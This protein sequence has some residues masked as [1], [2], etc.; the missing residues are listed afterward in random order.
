MGKKCDR[1]GERNS[2]FIELDLLLNPLHI[3]KVNWYLSLLIPWKDDFCMTRAGCIKL[4][5]PTQ[6]NRTFLTSL[7]LQ[8]AKIIRL[9]VRPSPYASLWVFELSPS[10]RIWGSFLSSSSYWVTPGGYPCHL[11]LDSSPMSG[12]CEDFWR[13]SMCPFNCIVLTTLTLWVDK[14]SVLF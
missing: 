14:D 9:G 5:C 8:K 13:V 10:G 6:L 1:S 11:L 4:S 12:R 7:Q 3:C 2:T